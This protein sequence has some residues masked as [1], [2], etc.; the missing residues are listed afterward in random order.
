MIVIIVTD[1]GHV[2]H[3]EIK[4][5]DVS[6]EDVKEANIPII[7]SK[8]YF[9]DKYVAKTAT[10][11]AE[12]ATMQA[13][14]KV[15][16]KAA[17]KSQAVKI[18]AKAKVAAKTAGKATK[19]ALVAVN[20]A[21][22]KTFDAVMD[23]GNKHAPQWMNKVEEATVQKAAEKFMK[24]KSGQAIAKQIEKKIGKEAAVSIAK[25]I[26][27]LCLGVGAACVY[28][29]LK[30]GEYMK[31]VGEGASALVAN[32]PGFG[33]LASFGLDGAMLSD[34][35]KIFEHGVMQADPNSHMASESTFVE[36]PT[37][38]EK[39]ERKVDKAEENR[40]KQESQKKADEFKKNLYK[41]GGKSNGNFFDRS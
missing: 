31:A 11:S 34:D 35:L 39:F 15:A 19:E 33:T 20:K 1:K 5:D 6:L 16:T 22:D 10:K 36:K 9:G 2:E 37:I 40:K 3:K 26:P 24:T 29:R 13:S 14:E 23:W 8:E 32:V 28:D 30:D 21:Y 25:K 38:Q 7:S 17:L 27:I 41:Y 18:G 12:D 4:L